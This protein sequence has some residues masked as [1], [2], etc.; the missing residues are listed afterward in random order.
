MMNFKEGPHVLCEARCKR[1]KQKVCRQPAMSN[2][3]CRLH[4]GKSTGPKTKEGIEKCRQARLKHGNYSKEAI[5]SPKESR[6]LIRKMK[7]F[8]H[9]ID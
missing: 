4:G 1:D 5:F 2:G 9:S 8:I 7:F 6:E 3:R